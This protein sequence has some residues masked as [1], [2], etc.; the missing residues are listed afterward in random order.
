MNLLAFSSEEVPAWGMLIGIITTAVVTIIAAFKSNAKLDE[1]KDRALKS[2]VKI[3]K[4]LR[5]TNGKMHSMT[6]KLADLEAEVKSLKDQ[7]TTLRQ[8]ASKAKIRSNPKKR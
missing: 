1:A 7:N 5:N 2:E 8:D 3:D 6:K 4:T